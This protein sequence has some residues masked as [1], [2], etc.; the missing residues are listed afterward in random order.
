MDII[1]NGGSH[2]MREREM[3]EIRWVSPDVGFGLFAKRFIIH[4]DKLEILKLVRLLV[5]IVV[6]WMLR[7]QRMIM[8]GHIISI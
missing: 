7:I 8:R 3:F 6:L 2:E 5:F 4:I 1:L